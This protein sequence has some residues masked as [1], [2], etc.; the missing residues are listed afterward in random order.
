MPLL[1]CGILAVSVDGQE[2]SYHL[3][4]SLTMEEMEKTDIQLQRPIK[5]EWNPQCVLF[6]YFQGHIGS[7]V[8]EHFPRALSNV[9]SPQG[10]S[11]LSQG[12]DVI[13]RNGEHVGT[14]YQGYHGKTSSPMP[15]MH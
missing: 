4:V 2:L 5:T 7:V 13:L 3:P 15:L 11:P 12:A 1:S 8:D 6:T 14:P 10:L 9:R